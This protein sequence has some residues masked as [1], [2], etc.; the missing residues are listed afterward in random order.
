MGAINFISSNPTTAAIR[1]NETR[2]MQ[3]A[4]AA[5]SLFAARDARQQRADMDA[6]YGAAADELATK[7][8]P[9]P[10]ALA[11][12]A[13]AQMYNEM[14]SPVP[15]TELAK[16]TPGATIQQAAPQQSVLSTVTADSGS[17]NVSALKGMR[18]TGKVRYEIALAQQAQAKE[19]QKRTDTGMLEVMKAMDA[20]DF[21]K[22]LILDKHYGTGQ[23]SVISDPNQRTVV[24]RVIQS[25]P[26]NA[27][28]EQALAYQDAAVRAWGETFKATGDRNEADRAAG[29]AGIKAAMAVQGKADAYFQDDAGNVTAVRG[30]KATPVDGARG[31][32]TRSVGGGSVNDQSRIRGEQ[33]DEKKIQQH[34]KE[35]ADFYT[36]SNME[37]KPVI[38]AENRGAYVA[39]VR[40]LGPDQADQRALMIRQKAEELATDKE[41][42]NVDQ[43]RFDKA[44]LLGMRA[45]GAKIRSTPKPAQSPAPAPA[46]PAAPK[47]AVATGSPL[48]QVTADQ[49]QPQITKIERA[50]S[51]VFGGKQFVATLSDGSRKVISGDEAERANILLN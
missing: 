41:T 27:T 5:E 37:G 33:W 50:G 25:I 45:M 43:E 15:A 12:V 28:A 31:R 24:R 21:D 20:G 22:A 36:S 48:A 6:A 19:A 39:M 13:P 38:N 14:G 7:T 34:I 49:S 10:S 40:S 9:M 8:K 4:Q 32:T 46:K 2:D 30:G 29:A 18:N 16:A 47:A 35:S 26:K 1:V 44:Y 51:T 11:T 3:Q 23:A 17:G 42:G